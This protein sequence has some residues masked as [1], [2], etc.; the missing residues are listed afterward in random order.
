MHHQD[1]SLSVTDRNTDAIVAYQRAISLDPHHT[2]AMT[3]L[4]RVYRSLGE[5]R[6]AEELFKKSV[7]CKP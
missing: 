7:L 2:T 4:A 1:A 5:N 6:K 3:S